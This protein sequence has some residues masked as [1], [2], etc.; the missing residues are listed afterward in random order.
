MRQQ[1]TRLYTAR[2][3]YFIRNRIVPVVGLI[4]MNIVDNMMHPL[5]K[6]ISGRTLGQKLVTSEIV[7]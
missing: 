3:Y 5:L 2:L 6:S 7:P 1:L 4:Q